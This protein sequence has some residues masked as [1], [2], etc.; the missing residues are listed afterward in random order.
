MAHTLNTMD[1]T[2]VRIIHATVRGWI[3]A[4]LL[5]TPLTVRRVAHELAL[6]ERQAR[7]GIAEAQTAGLVKSVGEDE[8]NR[9]SMR[10]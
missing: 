5:S 10:P 6:T 3:L 9:V 2:D 8:W 1:G 7:L 4:H